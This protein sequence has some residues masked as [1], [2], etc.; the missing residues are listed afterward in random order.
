MN[1]GLSCY[2]VTVFTDLPSALPW[3][4]YGGDQPFTQPWDHRRARPIITAASQGEAEHKAA[5]VGSEILGGRAV[6]VE[7]VEQICSPG[8]H[9]DEHNAAHRRMSA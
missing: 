7:R 8:A 6:V 5:I 2:R 3:T 1:P 9:R 4:M